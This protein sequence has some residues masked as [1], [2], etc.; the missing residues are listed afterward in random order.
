[1]RLKDKSVLVTGGAT[2]IGAGIARRFVAEGANVTISGRREPLLEELADELGCHYVAGDVSV[3]GDPE[4]M[5][6]AAL[7]AHGA[8]DVLV[9]NAG[10]AR[11]SPLADTTD[12]LL[13]M[14]LDINVKGPYRMTRA[15]LPHLVAGRGNVLNISSTLAMRG[16]AGGSAYGASKGAVNALTLH[17]AAELAPQG[18]RVNCICPAVVETPIFETMMPR[19]Q[20]AG[21]LDHMVSIHPIG[22]VGQ[23]SDVAG[24]ALYL[25]SAE[26]E[27]VTGVVLAV[28]GGV[29]AV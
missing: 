5:V 12:E 10:V 17:L 7:D 22:R 2:G 25:V 13:E 14:Q 8:L 27:W 4:R 29:T 6:R 28:D 20:V 16:I 19:E 24:A 15:A 18:V 26:A 9:N 1:M 21:M 3:P 23:P 11:F